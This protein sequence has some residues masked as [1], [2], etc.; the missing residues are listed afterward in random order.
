VSWQLVQA[1]VINRCFGS[2]QVA[3]QDSRQPQAWM[4]PL[5]AAQD[6]AEGGPGTGLPLWNPSP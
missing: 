3:K 4:H 6:G 2:E 1:L 5:Y